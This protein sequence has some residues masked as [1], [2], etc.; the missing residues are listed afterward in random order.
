LARKKSVGLLRWVKRI[1]IVVAVL[2]AI[3]LAMTPVYLVVDPVSVP[4]L[5]RYATGRPVVREWR[6]R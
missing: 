5:E 6:H 2:V 4:M 1:A 3:P